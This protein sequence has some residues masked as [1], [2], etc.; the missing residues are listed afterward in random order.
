LIS[1]SRLWYLEDTNNCGR[2]KGRER[3][4]EKRRKRKEV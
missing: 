3:R 4:K 2:K 1:L